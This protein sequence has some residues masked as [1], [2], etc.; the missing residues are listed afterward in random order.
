MF[1]ADCVGPLRNLGAFGCIMSLVVSSTC[2]GGSGSLCS[3][4]FGVFD[5]SMCTLL[6]TYPLVSSFSRVV[7]SSL[8]IQ[9]ECKRG[10]DSFSLCACSTT[11]SL[12]LFINESKYDLKQRHLIRIH[13]SLSE[14]KYHI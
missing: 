9:Y 14:I 10:I 8:V 11:L 6:V 5:I 13:P 12:L 2:G 3:V 1:F 7:L 4:L